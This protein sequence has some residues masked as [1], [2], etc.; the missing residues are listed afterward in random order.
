MGQDTAKYVE[1]QV[2]VVGA[3]VKRFYSDVMQDFLPPSELNDEKV[4][5]CNSALDKYEDVVIC[6]KPMMGMKIERPKF[7]EENS[8]ENSKIVAHT[9]RDI[10]RK[11]PRR[12]NQAN[13]PHVVSSPYSANRAEIDGYFRKRDDEN[14]HHKRDLDGRE[15]TTKSSKSVTETS[16]TN[17]EKKYGNEASS[18]CAISN[19]KC[20]ASN[21]LVGNMETTISVKDARCNSVMQSSNETEK[22]ESDNIS[23]DVSSKSIA[24]NETETGRLSYGDSS[25]ELDGNYI[26]CFIF[27]SFFILC[28]LGS[29]R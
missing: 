20:E 11:L 29:W 19:R 22:V 28:L 6:K 1:N 10:V 4:A 14:I 16:P 23:S 2:E 25:A 8:T 24:D 7:N 3:S 27:M 26:F 13:N 15:S 21:E 9:K 5:V 12:H 17:L 18:C